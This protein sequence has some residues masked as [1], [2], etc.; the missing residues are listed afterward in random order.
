MLRITAR[1]TR[2]SMA[3]KLEGKIHGP[4]VDELRDCWQKL[5]REG[6]GMP[7]KAVELTDVSFIDGRGKDLLLRM[8]R[9]GVSL[10]G[11]SDFIWRL[12]AD[13]KPTPA[14]TRGDRSI[15]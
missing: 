14:R 13:S 9:K 15:R 5:S 4:W 10:V 6:G 7:I 3:L 12:L 1:K 11:G 8:Q 2:G